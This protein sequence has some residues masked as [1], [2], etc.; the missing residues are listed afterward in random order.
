MLEPTSRS[1]QNASPA[2]LAE[3]YADLLRLHNIVGSELAS[4]MSEKD[5]LVSSPLYF[6][7]AIG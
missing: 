4:L 2:V 1:H 5:K 3:L 6:I 7:D